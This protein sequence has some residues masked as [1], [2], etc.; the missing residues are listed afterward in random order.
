M[1]MIWAVIVGM[2]VFFMAAA[3]LPGRPEAAGGRGAGWRDAA[4]RAGCCGCRS[5]PSFCSRDAGSTAGG[6]GGKA[7][8]SAVVPLPADLAAPAGGRGG[9]RGRAA[10]RF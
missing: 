3:L 4:V 7:I 8:A 9:R 5:C 6:R 10:Y 2:L 1:V